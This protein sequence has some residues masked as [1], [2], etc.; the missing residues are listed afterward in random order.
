MDV[1]GLAKLGGGG[2]LAGAGVKLL[3]S[4]LRRE[5]QDSSLYKSEL[6]AHDETKKDL[7][8]ERKLRKDAEM[9]LR[10]AREQHDQDRS[11]WAD[12]R[13]KD[14]TLREELKNQIYDLSLE[15]KRLEATMKS[16]GYNT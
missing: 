5:K 8:N 3:V 15:V 10:E 14:R 9:E 4:W 11:E 12:E 6:A 13:D 1:D 7:V 16:Q 2:I